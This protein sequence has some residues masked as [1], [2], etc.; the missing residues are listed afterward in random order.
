MQ[1]GKYTKQQPTSWRNAGNDIESLG[2]RVW[3]GEDGRTCKY[4]MFPERPKHQIQPDVSSQNAVGKGKSGADVCV[5]SDEKTINQL[6]H[7]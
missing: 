7:F 1:N 2:K 5:Q 4:Q 6:N 3:L